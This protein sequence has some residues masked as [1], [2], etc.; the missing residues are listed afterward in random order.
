MLPVSNPL[1]PQDNSNNAQKHDPYAAFRH[2]GYRHYTVGWVLVVLFTQVQS[3]ALQWEILQRTDS[4]MA[5]GL[6]GLMQIIPA[7]ILILPAGHLADTYDRR[8]VMMVGMVGTTMTSLGL[9]VMSILV[10]PLW[11]IYAVLFLDAVFLTI[12]RPARSA[13]LPL[14]VPA[15][16][17]A[18]AVTW[19]SS[20]FHLAL[21]VGPALGGL[22]IAIYIPAAFFLSATASTLFGVLLL[23]LQLRKTQE[24]KREPVS[25]HTMLGG[26]RFIWKTKLIL[27]A[28]TLDMVAVFLG[29]VVYLLPIFAKDILE[30]DAKGFGLMRAAPA[31]GAVLMS[32]VLAHLPPMQRAGRAL[33]WSVVGYGVATIGFGLSPW[34]GLSLLML[35]LT[36][37]LDMVSV[38][39]RHTL[40]QLATPDEMR[41]RVS[42]VNGV[43]ID[44]SNELGGFRAGAVAE[45]IGPVVTVVSGGIGTILVVG[46]TAL[47]IP[48][49]ARLKQLQD[50]KTSPT[51]TRTG[52]IERMPQHPEGLC[53]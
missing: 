41:G 21:I 6:V 10:A 1:L 40:V 33:L 12:A 9:G 48:A 16:N 15:E 4:P 22:V 27:G 44:V 5:L 14:L 34:F 47:T 13:M 26:F 29:G 18:N 28:I 49:L 3:V 39:V 35:F 37:V 43:F 42:A 38:V 50:I 31:I 53:K 11:S 7:L 20:L 17:F 2:T 24:N 45:F 8:R 51:G 19:N 52:R 23:T 36:G 30:V 25:L 46:I 32:V